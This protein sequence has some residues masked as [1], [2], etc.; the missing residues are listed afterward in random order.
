M[1]KRGDRNGKRLRE[2]LA[3]AAEDAERVADEV[4]RARREAEKQGWEFTAVTA[5]QYRRKLARSNSPLIIWQAWSGSV[6]AGSAAG[7]TVGIKN[8]DPVAHYFLYAHVFVGPS[9]I[10]PDVSEALTAVDA[11]FP[12]LTGPDNGLNLTAWDVGSAS[13]SIDVPS[14]MQPS[15][16]MGN[17]VLFQTTWHEAAIYLDR[18][19]FFLKVT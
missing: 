16:Y 8:P 12:R 4:E 18:A 1:A 9:N 19:L 5:D 2:A 6:A 14:G 3:Q 13:F 7:Y 15:T 10:A 11:R 17:A